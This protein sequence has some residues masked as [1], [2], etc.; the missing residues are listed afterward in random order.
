MP[1]WL[2]TGIFV[3]LFVALFEWPRR[4]EGAAAES[5]TTGW[6]RRLRSFAIALAIA[7]ATAAAVTYLFEEI[8]L[9]R[10]P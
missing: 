6:S 7:V 2:A 9:V 3:F 4:S 5:G 10:L 8:F 1:F